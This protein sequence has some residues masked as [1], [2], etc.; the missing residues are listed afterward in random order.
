MQSV[1]PFHPS[2]WSRLTSWPVGCCTY[3]VVVSVRLSPPGERE[4]YK[5]GL[6]TVYAATASDWRSPLGCKLRVDARAAAAVGRASGAAIAVC[7]LLLLCREAVC[8]S[9]GSVTARRHRTLA[10]C[11]ATV[12]ECTDDRC[13]S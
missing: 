8:S 1:G 10:D 11:F 5:R 9:S 4:R 13:S 6:C 2:I 7:T 3:S 12:S